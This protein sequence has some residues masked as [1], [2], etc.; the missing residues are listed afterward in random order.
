MVAFPGWPYR[1]P[2][3]SSGLA[4]LRDWRQPNH[5]GNVCKSLFN[6]STASFKFAHGK[7]DGLVTS[8]TN[9]GFVEF[10]RENLLFFSAIWALARK[11]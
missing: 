3:F 11:R 2:S 5:P 9:M 7:I 8:L 10:V 1:P 4:I 6:L